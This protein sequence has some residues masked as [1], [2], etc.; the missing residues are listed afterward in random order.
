MSIPVTTLRVTGAVFMI[1]VLASCATREADSVGSSS[2]SRSGFFKSKRSAE[3]PC[4]DEVCGEPEFQ[5]VKIEKNLSPSLLNPPSGSYRIGPGDELDIEVAEDTK[6][7]STSKVMPDGMLYYD[8]ANGIN[9]KGMSIRQVSEALASNLSQDYIDPVVTVN[10]SNAES[11]RYW[12][13]GHVKNPG[14]YPIKKPTTLIAALSN[15][16]GLG[17]TTF[18]NE[19]EETVDLS[20][21][22][23]IREKKLVPVD[24]EALVRDGD[25]SH[26][27][28]LRPND[29]IFIPSRQSNAIYVLGAVNNP[30]PVL[31]DRYS[32]LLSV[33]A[34]AGGPRRDA[35][36]T[37]ALII[38]GSTSNP[39]VS[40]V[41]LN[42][43][44][45]GHVLNLRVKGGDIVWVPKSPWT[46]IKKYTEEVLTTA[47]Q[48]IAVQEGLGL[49]GSSGT[50]GVTITAGGR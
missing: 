15:S 11:Q 50:A 38:R 6:T 27:V 16:Q 25:M 20:R 44:L 47:A 22:I 5:S 9:V 19:S 49:L 46:S 26:N 10:V 33:V 3:V 28:Y 34:S 37:K 24:F 32:N 1:G 31:A 21:A 17:M 18:G 48:A 43:L 13:L 14:A 45:R 35:V 23:L 42:Q 29:Y 39:E 41:N 2:P 4:H 40:V 12:I 8:V 36:V 7:R 30:G